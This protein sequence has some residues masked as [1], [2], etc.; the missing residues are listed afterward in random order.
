MT[1]WGHVVSGGGG[2]GGDTMD[3]RSIVAHSGDAGWSADSPGC[4]RST[5]E[6]QCS[7]YQGRMEPM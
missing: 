5:R 4:P 6:Q 3:G 2:G 1:V 7:M